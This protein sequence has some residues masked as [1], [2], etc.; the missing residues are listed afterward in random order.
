MNKNALIKLNKKF[1]NERQCKNSRCGGYFLSEADEEYCPMCREKG[2]DKVDV[3]RKQED[4]LY[5]EVNVVELAKRV[6]G[7]EDRLV[8]LEEA[9]KLVGLDKLRKEPKPKEFKS[10]KCENCGKK[11]TPASG[12]QSICHPCRDILIS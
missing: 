3:E 5:T 11:F 9:I 8:K 6:A 2:I 1:A 7:L 4:V 10:K 12:N